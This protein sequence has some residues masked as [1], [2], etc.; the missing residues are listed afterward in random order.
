MIRTATSWS[1][2]S[3]AYAAVAI[4]L[5]WSVERAGEVEADG[6]GGELGGDEH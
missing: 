3:M 5:A 6:R 2:M 1:W 4:V